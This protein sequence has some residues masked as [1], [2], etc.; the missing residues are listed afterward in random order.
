MA[1]YDDGDEYEIDSDG[2]EV[3]WTIEDDGRTVFKPDPSTQWP[4]VRE[5]Y[6]A[7]LSAAIDEAGAAWLAVPLA[8]G[9]LGWKAVPANEAAATTSAVALVLLGAAVLKE[10]EFFTPPR[11]RPAPKM[12]ASLPAPPLPDPDCWRHPASGA[13]PS[14]ALTRYFD[15]FA[16]LLGLANA[17]FLL[18]A[19]YVNDV[20]AFAA[21]VGG[22]R[23]GAQ[24]DYAEEGSCK[25]WLSGGPWPTE[26]VVDAFLFFHFIAFFLVMLAYRD[27]YLCCILSP[28]L[29]VCE[30]SFQHVLPNF[31]ECLWD[32]WGLDILTFNAFGIWLG[33]Q[34]LTWLEIPQY[35]LFGLQPGGARHA[36][37]TVRAVCCGGVLLLHT[38]CMSCQ[39][40]LKH[41]V[42]IKETSPWFALLSITPLL[43]ARS[44][45]QSLVRRHYLGETQ[46]PAMPRS[47][48]L[49]IILV[50]I[51]VTVLAT[52]VPT[53]SDFRIPAKTDL[54]PETAFIP[55]P[56]GQTESLLHA[57][58][59]GGE[60][61]RNPHN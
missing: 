5:P 59:L 40:F 30:A 17:A 14:S 51:Q 18:N 2:E 13:E 52:V 12:P 8:A 43:L 15:A 21:S 23:G 36:S 11:A 31:K 58:F 53:A 48:A 38:S 32:S 33:Y 25:L 34:L 45:M 28:L 35:D 20:D 10:S 1:L 56:E 7:R 4:P 26:G 19:L 16:V 29:E 61:T 47:A 44:G 50:I 54:S 41:V 55:L 22:A 42:A 24:V 39:F 27:V 60:H 9:M 37:V 3:G 46:L 6:A 57:L 49:I